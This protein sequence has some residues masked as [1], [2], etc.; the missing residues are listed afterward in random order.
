MTSHI[1]PFSLKLRESNISGLN[2][3]RAFVLYKMGFM[4]LVF[5]FCFLIVKLQV[6]LLLNFQFVFL[7]VISV[8]GI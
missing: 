4:V 5:L 1:F 2:L 6:T 3:M 8:L 7:Q